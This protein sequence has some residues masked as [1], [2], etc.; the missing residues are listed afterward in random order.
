MNTQYHA[1]SRSESQPREHGASISRREAMRRG[2]SGAAGLLLAGGL[3]ADASATAQPAKAKSVIQIWLGGGPSHLDTF[4]PK[5]EAGPDYCGPLNK[6][7]PTNVPRHPDR[8]AAAPAGQAGRQ[9]LHHPQHDPRQQRP[10][11]GRLHVQTGR[12]PGGRLVYPSVG[13]RGFAVQ[14]L[15][16]RLQGADSAL[17]RADPAAGT[18]FGGRLPGIAL[19]ALC[20]RR[21]PG[22]EPVRRGR[23]RRAG[24]LRPAAAGPTRSAAQAQHAGTRHARRH[25]AG[26]L[27]Q[28]RKSRPTT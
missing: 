27:R 9:V 17:H 23:R 6:P 26:R 24:Y 16:R 3:S 19:Q 21:R 13:R 12:T 22:A 10:R 28:R 5:P 2:L 8:R 14:G 15:R 11:D 7:I 25:P 1:G 4:D 18:V 20:H